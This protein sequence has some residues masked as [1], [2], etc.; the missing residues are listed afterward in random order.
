MFTVERA[1]VIHPAA[2]NRIDLPCHGD[3][4]PAGAV[5]QPPRPHF[6]IDLLQGRF[7]DRGVERAE[8]CAPPSASPTSYASCIPRRSIAP[9]SSAPPNSPPNSTTYAFPSTPED[10][11]PNRPPSTPSYGAIA[12]PPP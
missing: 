3:E 10:G 6:R 7:T 9:P 11:A 12:P 8:R 1:I 5:V 4:L 2:D